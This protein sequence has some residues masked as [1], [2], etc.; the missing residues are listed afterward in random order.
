MFFSI[1]VCTEIF[2]LRL[3]GLECSKLY[4]P[5]LGVFPVGALGL[6]FQFHLDLIHNNPSIS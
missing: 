3:E 2:G 4:V 6:V 5:D 1:I